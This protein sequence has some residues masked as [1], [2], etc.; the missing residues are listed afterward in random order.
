MACGHAAQDPDLFYRAHKTCEVDDGVGPKAW[1]SARQAIV[2]TPK[3]AGSTRGIRA[4]V[5]DVSSLNCR[6]K[7]AK[8]P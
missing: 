7:L 5:I 6:L 8:V 1:R 4:G 3:R 2:F